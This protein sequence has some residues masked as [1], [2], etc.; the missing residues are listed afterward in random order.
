[1]EVAAALVEL[2]VAGLI[3]PVDRTAGDEGLYDVTDEGRRHA[4]ESNSV[5]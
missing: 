4:A 1:M 3:V 2:E 5:T